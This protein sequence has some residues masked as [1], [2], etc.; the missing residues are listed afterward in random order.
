[1]P[2]G[3]ELTQKIDNGDIT[4]R[5]DF[6]ARARILS[7]DYGWDVDVARKIWAFGPD[8]V[9]PNLLCDATKAVQYLSEIKDS[10]VA[11]FNWVT[12]EGVIA[13]ENMRGICFQVLDVTMHA[14][15][16]HRG[17]GQVSRVP[18]TLCTRLYA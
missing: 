3:D 2:L 1:L 6:K 15:A 5:D 10:V 9:G 4:P 16:I 8:V 7:D 14:D 12:K 13:E 18:I 17:G 11:G